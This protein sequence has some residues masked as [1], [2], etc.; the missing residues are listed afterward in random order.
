M[1]APGELI[2]TLLNP[3]EITPHSDCLLKRFINKTFQRFEIVSKI[4]SVCERPS[5]SPFNV[6]FYQVI[7]LHVP[8]GSLDRSPQI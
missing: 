3:F 4:Y 7:L 5:Y 2:Q 8:G 1:V 6:R